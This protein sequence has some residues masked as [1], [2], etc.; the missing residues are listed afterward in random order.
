MTFLI[1][2]ATAALIFGF[3]LGYALA[4]A[5]DPEALPRRTA[6]ALIDLWLLQHEGYLVGIY[7]Q[8]YMAEASRK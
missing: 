2:I 5:V 6:G 3:W 8:H 4:W 1:L 7:M